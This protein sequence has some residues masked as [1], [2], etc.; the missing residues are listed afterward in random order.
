MEILK[1]KRIALGLTL[2]E[3]AEK[4]HLPPDFI[5]MIEEGII[6]KP[7]AHALWKIAGL[8]ELDYID[9]CIKAGIIKTVNRDLLK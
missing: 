3:A 4:S 8:Y 7:A 9:L 1:N 6:K 5:R 2:E